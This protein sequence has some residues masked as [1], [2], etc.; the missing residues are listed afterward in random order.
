MCL[1]SFQWQPDA[2][3]PF[4]LAANRDEFYA[5]PTQPLHVWQDSAMPPLLAGRDLQDGGTWL[6]VHRYN[7]RVAA[8]T[9]YRA[10][11]LQQRNAP[12]RG[13][14]VTSFLASHQ[15]ADAF[16]RTLAQHNA[17]H[18]PFNLLL[19][20]GHSLVGYESRHRRHFALE[21]GTWAVSN[22][23]FH[24][25][26]PKLQQLRAGLEAA[27]HQH[28]PQASL[29]PALEAEIWPLLSHAHQAP[30]ALLPSTGI[31]VER[32]R[33]LSST[34][35]RT[36][37]YGTRASTLLVHGRSHLTLVERS[38]TAEGFAG[39]ARFSLSHLQETP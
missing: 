8:L 23:D 25:P 10:P 11:H 20:D 13:H 2:P 33:A 15:S 28:P 4:V 19:F 29:W 35:I 3:I 9:N 5:R 6:G 37:D 7:G 38:F 16:A 14:I 39:E 1:L 18:N 36:A 34:F 32:E 26:W 30:D 12:S 27:L 21:P 24:T 31:S 17:A 22:A